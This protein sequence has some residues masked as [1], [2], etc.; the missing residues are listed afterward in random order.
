MI[1][2]LRGK[3]RAGLCEFEACLVYIWSAG[4]SGDGV[5]YLMIPPFY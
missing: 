1:L 3:S 2:D 4:P 5:H